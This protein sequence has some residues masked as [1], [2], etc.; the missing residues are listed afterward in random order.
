MMMGLFM[1]TFLIGTLWYMM[2]IG[3]A[4]ILHDRMQEAAD[5]VVFTSAAVHARGMN[6]IAAVNVLMLAMVGLYIIMGI[7][8]DILTI[9]ARALEI[10]SATIVGAPVCGPFVAPAEAAAQ[11]ATNVWK[12]YSNLMKPAMRVM[13]YTQY[14]AGI[15][16][17]IASVASSV[18]VGSKYN[19]V[20]LAVSPSMIAGNALTGGSAG[21]KANNVNLPPTG[22]PPSFK[23]ADSKIG[24]PIKFAHMDKLCDLAIKSSVDA[25]LNKLAEV[26]VV[27]NILDL[28]AGGFSVRGTLRDV[29]AGVGVT[30]FCNETNLGGLDPGFDEFWG[31][32][33]PK[34]MWEQA[35][36]GNE[37][38]QVWSMVLPKTYADAAEGKVRGARGP[39]QFGG[40][41]S[42]IVPAYTSQAEFYFDC[43]ENWET[44]NA[45]ERVSFSMR[46]RVR[47]RRLTTPN[48]LSMLVGWASSSILNGN[49]MT[50]LKGKVQQT[51]VFDD[52]KKSVDGWIGKNGSDALFGWFLKKSDTGITGGLQQV[53]SGVKGPWESTQFLKDAA[54]AAE[55]T[56]NPVIH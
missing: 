20:G 44:C 35:Q 55:V 23:G 4:L 54:R 12:T 41:G 56:G 1:A 39:S 38:T 5:S 7:V 40:A 18:S 17:P 51:Q 53:F 21:M 3:D 14:G 37:W 33:G 32:N 26:P 13:S 28:S 19:Q 15:I 34:V 36:N 25:V 8:S 47:V 11:V 16:Y 43:T 9:I 45:D 49:M 48:F 2:G 46:W 22:G 24:L 27:G 10:C 30:R 29:I 31:Q 6:F 52:A 50:W 42:A